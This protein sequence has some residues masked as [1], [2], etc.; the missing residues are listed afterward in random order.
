MTAICVNIA[1][2]YTLFPIVFKLSGYTLFRRSH[3]HEFF[4]WLFFSGKLSHFSTFRNLHVRFPRNVLL[5]AIHDS[6][7]RKLQGFHRRELM[8]VDVIIIR[9]SIARSTPTVWRTRTNPP[10]LFTL[11]VALSYIGSLLRWCDLFS[12]DLVDSLTTSGLIF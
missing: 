8:L 11:L 7:E 9:S 12:F 10:F 4:Y 3:A 1:C 5:C 6:E 2:T